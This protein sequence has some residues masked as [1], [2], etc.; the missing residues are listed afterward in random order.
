MTKSFAIKLTCLTVIILFFV[1]PFFASVTLA[2]PAERVP[3]IIGFKEAQDAGLVRSQGGE[4][5]YVYQHILAIAASVPQQAV[6]ALKKNPKVAYVEPDFEVYALPQTTPWGIQKINAPQA[7][8]AFSDKGTGIKVAILDTGIDTAHPD[9]RVAGGVTY[10]IGTTTYNDDHGHGT[11]VAGIVAALDNGIGVVGVAPEAALYAV[12]VLNSQGSGSISAI[13]M[14][15]EWCIS[16][17]IQ[18]IS[19]SF[20]ASSDPISLHQ[21]CDAAYNAGIVLVAAAG[22]SG[23]GPETTT[24]PAKYSS[25]IAVG[26][27][28]SNDVVADWSSRGQELWVTA[29]GVSVY[30]TY[31][32]SSY[33]TMS[34]TSMACPHVT[35]TVALILKRAAHTPAEVRSI[36]QRTAVKTAGMNGWTW[37]S[38]YGFGRVDAYAAVSA[39]QTLTPDFSVSAS[40]SALTIGAGASGSSTIT[41]TSLNG[42]SGTVLLTASAPTGLS[43]ALDP[44]SLAIASGGSNSSKLSVTV[45]PDTPAGAYTVT[46]TGTSGSLSHSATVTVNVQ[47]K[48]SAPQNLKATAGDA[49]VTLSWSAPSSDGGSPI[50]NYKIY[51]GNVQG[52]E[53]PLT[54]TGNVLAYTDTAVTNGQ[55]YYYQV[56]AINSIGE[57]ARSHEVSATPSASS[58]RSL[59]VAVT[60]DKTSYRRGSMV[61]ITVNV[62]DSSTKSGIGGA[63]VTVTVTDS[64]GV[65]TIRTGITD[66][67]GFVYFKYK[68]Q[69]KAP[70]GTYRVTAL[71]LATGYDPGNGSTT[72]VVV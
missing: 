13:D 68:I 4:I 9:L 62:T 17:G 1:A 49:Q 51:R 8:T 63:A 56:T 39:A 47:T 3:I 67:N 10:V 28:D 35:G 34:G 38:A 2:Q 33:A 20:G 23:P 55:T 71:A 31:M 26:A 21:E 18:V 42:F 30:S 16:K 72:F 7:W 61:Y 27:T 43:A 37:T 46:V 48:P 6:D 5:K 40:P 14:G 50:T 69:P 15:I 66:S 53:T 32:G 54:T 57:S 52:G 12:K 60:T 44:S 24:Y 64:K 11:H 19:M 45:S 29:P 65:P 22:N 36:L 41:V 25:V 58:T 59:T 70:L